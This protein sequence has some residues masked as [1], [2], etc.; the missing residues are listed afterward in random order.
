MCGNIECVAS[1]Y[2]GTCGDHA[3]WTFQNGVLTITGNGDMWD[4]DFIEPEEE[5]DEEDETGD[6]PE[7][8]D[9]AETI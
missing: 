7:E 2:S 5:S 9:P 1:Q 3:E 4:F 6:E 8:I